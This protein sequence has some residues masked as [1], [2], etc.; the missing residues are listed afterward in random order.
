MGIQEEAE[1]DMFLK[2]DDAAVKKAVEG[3]HHLVS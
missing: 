3:H 2:G 1:F